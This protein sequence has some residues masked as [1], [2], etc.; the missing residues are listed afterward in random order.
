LPLIGLLKAY[1]KL[2]DRDTHR[3]IREKVTGRLLTLDR[4]LEPI[5]PAVLSLLCVPVDEMSWQALDP[6]ARRQRT[7]DAVKRLLLRESRNQPLLIVFEDL[8][9]IDAETQGLVDSLV[10]SLPSRG[11]SSLSAIAL[12]STTNGEARRSTPRSAW[13]RSPPRV[14]ASF[15]RG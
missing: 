9:W 12:S 7:V 5:L 4:T 8:H 13:T 6:A 3:E 10:E 15:S 1:F 14:P 11:Y 2:G